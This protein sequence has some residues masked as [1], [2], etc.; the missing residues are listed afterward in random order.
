MN[1]PEMSVRKLRGLIVA[2]LLLILGGCK[3][4]LLHPSGDIAL[5]QRNLIYV[6]TILMLL[7]IVPVIAL[8]LYF[9]RHYRQTNKEAA[10]DPEWHHST[11]LEL[12]IWSAPLLIIIALGSIT[13]I[14]THTLDPYRPLARIDAN[15]TVP[16]GTKPL[17][18]EAVALDWKWLFLYPDLGIATV[19]ELAAPINTPIKFDIT[20]TT[21]MNA[22]FVP[23]LAGQIYAMP[24]MNTQLH[25]V[26]N[27]PGDF[28]GFSANYSGAGFTDMKF[29]FKGMSQS[30]FDSWVASIKAGGGDLTGPVFQ[31]LEKPSEREPVHTY[32]TFT[33]GLYDKIVNLCVDPNKMCVSDMM[34]IDEQGGLG[35]GSV[36]NVASLSYDRSRAA[37][38]ARGNSGYVQ[39]LC[40]TDP[41]PVPLM[42]SAN[43]ESAASPTANLAP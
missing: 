34:A 36:Y 37:E 23:A 30:D 7:I 38:Y 19:N 3:A 18:V 33:A 43:A 32:A 6:S 8:T 22:F 20:S 11:K 5:Q 15:T 12:V 39:A 2:P 31:Q 21:V 13:W 26:I 42:S 28:E 35:A 29:T 27:Q 16:A 24:A 10:Y 1:N 4:V 17:R 25:A 41:A 40:S 9:A 14:T